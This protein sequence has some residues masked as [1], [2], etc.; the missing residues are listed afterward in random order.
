MGSLYLS[1]LVG[2]PNVSFHRSRLV[3]ADAAVRS[4][5]LMIEAQGDVWRGHRRRLQWLPGGRSRCHVTHILIIL[6]PRTGILTPSSRPLPFT[7]TIP[8][9][10]TSCTDAVAE[11]DNI[12]ET[13]TS[14]YLLRSA[15]YWDQRVCMSGCQVAYLINH[16]SKLHGIFC[17]C[18]L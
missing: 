13:D 11:Y 15:R 10:V 8:Y 12:P 5:S 4:T 9:F 1:F 6:H 2:H 14:P 16:N 18:Y 17:T 7:C 3:A